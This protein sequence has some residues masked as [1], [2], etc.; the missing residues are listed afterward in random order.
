MFCRKC[1]KKNLEDSSFCEMCGTK[2]EKKQEIVESKRVVSITRDQFK[3]Y[4]NAIMEL[5]KAKMILSRMIA[6]LEDEISEKRVKLPYK[7][8]PYIPKKLQEPVLD[9]SEDKT[10]R[11]LLSL[12]LSVF[13]IGII[14]ILWIIVRSYSGYELT[15]IGIVLA[16]IS[17]VICVSYSFRVESNSSKLRRYQQSVEDEKRKLRENK[18]IAEQ[19]EGNRKKAEDVIQQI[20]VSLDKVKDE[21]KNATKELN[22]LY[23]LGILHREYRNL[24][25]VASFY[26]YF[27]SRRCSLLEGHEGAYNLYE[28]ERRLDMICTGI[29]WI[30]LNQQ[31]MIQQLDQIKDNQTALYGVVVD[32]ENT[33]QRL[34]SKIDRQTSMQQR[35]FAIME[36]NQE[37][38]MRISNAHLQ[39][40]FLSDLVRS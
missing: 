25:A 19:Y 3:S 31:Q 29:N 9:T 5:E 14:A 26:Q 23:S 39:Y 36:V 10:K 37:Q 16:V 22:N 30:G 20:K 8:N 32:M 4:F 24:E 27:D 12:L 17:I 2:I 15:E 7:P 18:I 13:P 40:H 6:K 1:G 33:I 38:I 21:L 11:F 34:G 28:K 35:H